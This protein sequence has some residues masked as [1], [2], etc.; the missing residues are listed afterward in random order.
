MDMGLKIQCVVLDSSALLAMFTLGLRVL[1]Q[2]MSIVESPIVPIVPYPIVNELMKL[3][4]SGRPGIMKAAR[5]ALDYVINNLSIAGIEASPDDSVVEVSSRY[6]CIAVTLDV[7]LMRRLRSLGIRV[8][9]LRA[10]S[11]RLEADFD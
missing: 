6:G 10:S 3:S 11:F 2:V 5:S 4:A 1:D 9:Y 8:V 7:K